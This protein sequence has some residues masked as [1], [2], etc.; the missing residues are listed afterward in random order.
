MELSYARGTNTD[1]LIAAPPTTQGIFPQVNYQ[2]TLMSHT[3]H[4][5]W[6]PLASTPNAHMETPW[7]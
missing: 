6:C 2:N 4:R 7:V 1:Q 5:A 3:Q